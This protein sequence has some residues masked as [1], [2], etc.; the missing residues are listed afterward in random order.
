MLSEF[1][2]A[3][4]KIRLDRQLLLKEMAEALDVTSAFLSSVETGK[5]KVPKD[6]VSKLCSLYNLT[7]VECDTLERASAMT[8]QEIRISM[9]NATRSQR[10]LAFSLAKALDDLTDDDV[11]RIMNAINQRGDKNSA[12]HPPRKNRSSKK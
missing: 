10:E 6:F 9:E 5:R 12:F 7:S 8:Q 2:I 4:R 3:L 11:E 1:G